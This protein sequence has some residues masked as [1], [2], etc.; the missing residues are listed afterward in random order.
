MATQDIDLG[1]FHI[2]SM[3][4]FRLT[5]KKDGIPWSGIDSVV[6]TFEK[7]GRSNTATTQFTRNMQFEDVTGGIWYYDTTVDDLDVT[8]Y[9]TLGVKIT[10]GSVVKK[11]PYEISF[12]VTSQP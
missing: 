10:D 9:W 6:L 7:P 2:G 12:H 8:G 11:Y 4:R 5:I 1:E 3:D